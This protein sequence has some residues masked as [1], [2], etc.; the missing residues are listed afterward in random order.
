MKKKL[1]SLFL[2]AVLILSAF[3]VT[4]FSQ[5]T[6][7]TEQWFA[8][9]SNEFQMLATLYDSDYVKTDSFDIYFKDNKISIKNVTLF[10]DFKVDFIYNGDEA[11]FCPSGFPFIRFSVDDLM[12]DFDGALESVD[13][14]ENTVFVKSYEQ[15]INSTVYYIEEFIY[16]DPEIDDSE[17]V[18]KYCFSGDELKLIITE[19]EDRI[20]HTEIVSTDVSDSVFKL[21]IFSINLTPIFKMLQNIFFD[22]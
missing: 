22:Y 20:Y 5:E 12:S 14:W 7:K 4:A 16:E 6:T 19:S 1:I 8:K 11:V 13:I 17:V 21:P 9:N 3:S 10:G 15:K 18:H 2:S